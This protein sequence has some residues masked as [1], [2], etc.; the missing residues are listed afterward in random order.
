MRLV[1]IAT[2]IAVMMALTAVPVAAAK[3]YFGHD[4]WQPS[5]T[6]DEADAGRRCFVFCVLFACILCFRVQ[7]TNEGGK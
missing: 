4:D 3:S 1:K 2:G 7:S 5:P 6:G